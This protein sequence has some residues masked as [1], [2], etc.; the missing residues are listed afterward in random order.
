MRGGTAG[1]LTLALGLGLV[2]LG[3]PSSASA[4]CVRT[5]CEASERDANGCCPERAKPEPKPAEE[6]DEAGKDAA[7]EQASKATEARERTDKKVKAKEA[8]R[9]VVPRFTPVKW[10]ELPGGTFVMGGEGY[11]RDQPAHRVKVGPFSIAQTETTVAQYEACVRAGKCT[12][13]AG[14]GNKASNYGAAGRDEHPINEVSYVAAERFCRWAGGRLPTE[15]EWE[16]AARS[17]GRPEM[18]PWGNT[19]A[20]CQ[21]AVMDE[22]GE[23]NGNEGCGVGTTHE[24]CS[25]K[26]GNTAQGLCDMAG[27]VWE[28]VYDWYADDYY[29]WGPPANPRGPERGDRRVVRGGAYS[30]KYRF[31]PANERDSRAP[32]GGALDLGFRCAK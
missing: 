26:A 10:I 24:V 12:A 2:A 25:R 19:S 22:D 8:P 29:D 14:S 28:W 7:D 15:A 23:I 4:A 6:P 5:G 1:A 30:T 27:N 21:H 11:D 13:P 18:F 3:W 16:Y 9:P 20:S 31:L 32:D 17:A